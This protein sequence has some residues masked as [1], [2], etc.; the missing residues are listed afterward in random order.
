M[1]GA[2]LAERLTDVASFDAA[3]DYGE[4][5]R[6]RLAAIAAHWGV[7]LREEWTDAHA[8]QDASPHA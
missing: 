8:W 4:Y 6:A 1:K 5:I 2:G 3:H 7:D